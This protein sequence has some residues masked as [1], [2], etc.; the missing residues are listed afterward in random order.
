MVASRS[1]SHDKKVDLKRVMVHL[2]LLIVMVHL[3]GY[4]KRQPGI[5]EEKNKKTPGLYRP[6]V[7]DY[8][9]FQNGF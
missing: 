4:G 8:A 9:Y 3:N 6:G 1:F 7:F 2:Y 5:Q